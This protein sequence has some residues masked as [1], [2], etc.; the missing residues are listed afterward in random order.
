MYAWRIDDTTV[1]LFLFCILYCDEIYFFFVDL[2]FQS[3]YLRKIS[4]K[5]L[6]RETKS[7]NPIGNSLPSNAASSSNN[8]PDSGI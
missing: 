8:P 4:L 5:M 1:I 2:S 6:T 7:V 3:D